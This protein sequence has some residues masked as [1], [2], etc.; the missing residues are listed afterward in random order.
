MK[1]LMILA[2]T[3]LLLFFVSACGNSEKTIGSNKGDIIVDIKNNADFDIYSIEIG[4]YK[5]EELKATQGS[6]NAD[7]SK[8]KKGESLRFELT[9]NDFNLDGEINLEVVIEK[10]NN[11][12]PKEMSFK[13]ENAQQKEYFLEIVG[14]SITNPDIKVVK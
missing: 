8:L 3:M 1:R 4:V 7:G 10:I 11:E 14:D 13:L 12:R 9:G 5:N 6:M 2:I